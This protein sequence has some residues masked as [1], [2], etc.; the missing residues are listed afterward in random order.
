MARTSSPWSGEHEAGSARAGASWERSVT[1]RNRGTL[2]PRRPQ[3]LPARTAAAAAAAGG[4]RRRGSAFRVAVDHSSRAGYRRRHVRAHDPPPPASKAPM[5]KACSPARLGCPPSMTRM[6]GAG[7]S[8]QNTSRVSPGPWRAPG[9]RYRSS[10]GGG[11]G[12]GR[13]PAIEEEGG[14][15]RGG[16]H[17][18]SEEDSAEL[19][20]A[21]E[22][23]DDGADGVAAGV[24]GRAT[25]LPVERVERGSVIAKEP[26]YERMLIESSKMQRCLEPSKSVLAFALVALHSALLRRSWLIPD[27]WS[28]GQKDRRGASAKSRH[29]HSGHSERLA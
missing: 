14:G 19:E 29:S 12:H 22:G 17:G 24:H 1:A 10:P 21:L 28:C 2:Q 13:G 3:L 4:V 26:A 20:A 16:D 9:P 18:R 7:R 15:A 6:P 23:K 8:A 5:P 11:R 25:A 27:L